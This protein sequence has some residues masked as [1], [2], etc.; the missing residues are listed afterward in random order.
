[1]NAPRYNKK[2]LSC[3]QDVDGEMLEDDPLGQPAEVAMAPQAAA[4]LA[5]EEAVKTASKGKPQVCMQTCRVSYGFYRSTRT[6]ASI[7]I[8]TYIYIYIIYI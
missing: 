4:E 8:Y 7:Y 1:M 3:P 6:I 2:P 5:K